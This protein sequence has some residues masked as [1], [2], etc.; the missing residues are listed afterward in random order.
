MSFK[1]FL[2]NGSDY[3]NILRCNDVNT[4]VEGLNRH[5]DDHYDNFFPIKQ[6]KCN[7]SC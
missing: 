4:A 3:E 1:N 6:I 2:S 7:Q 5:I